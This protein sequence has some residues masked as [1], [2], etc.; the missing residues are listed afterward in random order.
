MSRKRKAWLAA[1][2]LGNGA[3]AVLAAYTVYYLVSRAL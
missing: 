1:V 2:V 3:L